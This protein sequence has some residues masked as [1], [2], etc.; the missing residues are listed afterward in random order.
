MKEKYID[1]LKALRNSAFVT[2]V[3]KL[4]GGSAIGQA[5]VMLSTPLITRLYGPADMGVFGLFMSFI[6]FASVG[7]ALRYDLAIVAARDKFEADVLL[8]TSIALAIP[9]VLIASVVLSGMIHFSMLGFAALPGWSA[10]AMFVALLATGVFSSLRFWYVGRRKFGEISLA[11]VSQ[12]AGRAIIPVVLGWLSTG[13][14]GLLGGEILGRMLGVVRLA[15]GAWPDVR[16][17]LAALDIKQG[18]QVLRRYWKYPAVFLP[19]S[20]IDAL[21]TSLPLPIISS[22]FGVSAAGQ[23]FLVYRLASVPAA[24]ISAGVA[25][26][27]HAKI[28]EAARSDKSSVHRIMKAAMQKLTVVSLGIYLPTALVSPF[29]FALVFGESWQQAGILMAIQSL[30]CM[31]G[32]VVS[33]L[34]RALAIS[35]NPELKLLPDIVRLIM[36]VSSFWVCYCFGMTFLLT[37]VVFSVLTAISEIFYMFIIWYATA[38]HRHLPLH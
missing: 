31:T 18:T 13:W 32:L 30:A 4:A 8:I 28:A 22:L 15:R 7:V 3:V 34:S 29:L 36:P 17:T 25:D 37:M 19:S 21:A 16:T 10:L 2:N 9:C 12:G 33:P 1:N 35:K 20:M 27:F 23:Y 14:T 38:E 6:A 24:L 5:L 11:L 26:V